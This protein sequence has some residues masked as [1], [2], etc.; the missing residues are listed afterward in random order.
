MSAVVTFR[1]K[2]TACWRFTRNK[3]LCP[4]DA[5]GAGGELDADLRITRDENGVYLTAMN[6]AALATPGL[7]RG[8]C[9]DAYRKEAKIRI[10]GLGPGDDICLY[11][12]DRNWSHVFLT[13][14]VTRRS[15]RIAIWQITRKR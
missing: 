6:G 7:P 2:L 14:E 4:G 1:C 11:T 9:Q 12:H 8:D 10:D 5:K 15:D 3:V 13:E